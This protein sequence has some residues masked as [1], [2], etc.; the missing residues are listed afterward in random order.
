MSDNNPI[1][2]HITMLGA[3]GVGKTSLLAS[4]YSEFERRTSELYLQLN[5]DFATSNELNDRLAALQS[6]LEDHIVTGPSN[7]G[8]MRT[9]EFGVGLPFKT[10][11]VNL[12]FRD[13]PGAW[14]TSDPQSVT[15]FIRSSDVIIWAID[16]AALK[17][18]K[19][20][21]SESINSVGKITEFFKHAL[22]NLPEA[23][24]KLILLV[25]MKCET[26]L[27]FPSYPNIHEIKTLRTL[28]EDKWGNLINLIKNID[29]GAERFAVALTPVQ[30]LGKVKYAFTDDS[31]PVNPKFVFTRTTKDHPYQPMHVEQILNY[32]L[33]FLLR[34]YM[35]IKEE[36]MGMMD[37]LVYRIQELFGNDPNAH[38]GN[39][40]MD[41]VRKQCRDEGQ[42]FKILH[43]R[44]LLDPPSK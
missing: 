3:R 33:A 4:V 38:F 6:S 23:E 36:Q 30:T 22:Q 12:T 35:S 19:G 27:T 41:L 29:P 44:N 43:G 20:Q 32:S 39:A 21:Y 11:D 10:P 16:T 26:W 9:F 5:P 40:V 13:Y 14:I 15:E 28:I 8:D 37:W 7:T 25:P 18:N 42:G 2:L 17:T 31:D 34:R 24:K 1:Q